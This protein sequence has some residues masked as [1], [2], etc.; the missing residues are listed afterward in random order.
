MNPAFVT[1]LNGIILVVFSLY[2]YL[3]SDTPSFTALIPAAFGLLFV[4]AY[5]FMK[6]DNKIVAHIVVVLT[7]VLIIALFKPLTGAMGREDTMAIIRVGIM[8]ACAVLA[9]IVYIRSF[10]LARSKKA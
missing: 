9:F 2:G 4:L 10:T 5:P 6:K 3:D 8:L 1:I 7:L